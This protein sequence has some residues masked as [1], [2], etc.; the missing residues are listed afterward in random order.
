[1]SSVGAGRDGLGHLA[2][3]AHAAV[4]D[5][6]DVAAGALEVLV[7]GGSHVGDG[8]HLRHADAEHLARGA[9]G[10]GP[11]AHEDGRDALLHQRRG[12]L[13][14]GGVA[15]G[16]GDAH[17]PRELGQLQ[18]LV[19]GGEVLGGRDLRL[20]QEDVG[21]VLGAE[22][23]PATRRGR[24]GRDD[25]RRA[26]GMQLGDAAGH[27]GLRRWAP[28]R[29]SR[30]PPGPR[31]AAAAGDAL[32]HGR[33]VLVAHLHAL[34]VHDGQSAQAGQHTG[35]AHVDDRVHGGRQHR[36]VQRQAREL[37]RGVDVGRLDRG[38]ARG[39]A[40]RH[41]IRRRGGGRRPS[42]LGAAGRSSTLA[43]SRR[44]A[45]LDGHVRS[46]PPAARQ[47]DGGG[48]IPT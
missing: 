12:G 41:R 15:D 22:R 48:S 7:A 9:G 17:E 2:A 39:P 44:A 33:R 36:D 32:E 37:D 16:H 8:R 35:R 29:P 6:R 26:G 45:D 19:A 21:A 13:V 34:E 28:R 1:M 11:D 24:G 3:A 40:R 38:A 18:R 46:T 4:A 43:R 27:D 42:R 14:R 31:R 23:A 10:A 20:D 30:G 25:R 5:D 47:A